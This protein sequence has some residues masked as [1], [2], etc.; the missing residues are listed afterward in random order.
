MG[1]DKIRDIGLTVTMVSG[2]I[3]PSLFLKLS[4]NI[5]TETV[6]L[7]GFCSFMSLVILSVGIAIFDPY[8]G[9]EDGG[10]EDEEDP[11]PFPEGDP[12]YSWAEMQ[13]H[14][15]SIYREPR[16]YDQDSHLTS[17]E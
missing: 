14:L 11:E 10:W 4:A 7:M 2:V 17:N 1:N 9:W 12:L 3:L 15:H 5:S 16:L 8:R 13:A 6:I